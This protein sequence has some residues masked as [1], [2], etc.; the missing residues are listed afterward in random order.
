MESWAAN[1]T[2]NLQKSHTVTVQCDNSSEMTN[3]ALCMEAHLGFLGPEAYK[4]F[5][6]LFMK[7]NTKL[8]IK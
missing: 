6:A 3:K 4:I 7:K 1:K 5:G 2:E 8:G